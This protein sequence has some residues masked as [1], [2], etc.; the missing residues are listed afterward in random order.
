MF[1]ARLRPAFRILFALLSLA[2][3]LVTWRAEA[4]PAKRIYVGIY[5]RDITSFDQKNGVFDADVELWAKW[6]GEFEKDK[7]V[8]TNAATVDQTFL[9][10]EHD[11]AWHSAR[12]RVR[13]TFRGQFPLQ[14]FPFDTQTI[15]ITLELPERRCCL[16]CRG[17]T[18]PIMPDMLLDACE[19]HGYFPN[20]AQNVRQGLFAA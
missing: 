16:R 4:D 5:L 18:S 7:L 12:W 17:C 9:E 15:A 13:G 11:G 6:M 20:L 1:R 3:L 14:R 8:L 19:A 2:V 10:E